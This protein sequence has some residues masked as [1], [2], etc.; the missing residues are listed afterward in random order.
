MTDPRV[1][2]KLDMVIG[3]LGVIALLLA[4]LVVSDIGSL[5]LFA[6]IIIGIAVTIGTRSYRRMLEDAQR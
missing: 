4:L 6:V 1:L 5:G 2:V 3:L